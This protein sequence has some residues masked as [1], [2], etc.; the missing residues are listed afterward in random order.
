MPINDNWG[1][2]TCINVSLGEG[3]STRNYSGIFLIA[4]L[5]VYVSKGDGVISREESDAM[6]D[7]MTS[8]LGISYAKALENLR[9]AIMFLSDEKDAAAQLS[10]IGSQLEIAQKQGIL[11]L[12]LYV[13]DADGN[14]S[15]AEMERIGVAARVLGLNQSTVL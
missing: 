7:S 14:R 9:T 15:S 4:A 2:L 5:L 8:N 1:K 11:E 3:D 10:S 12:M 13:A 6:L